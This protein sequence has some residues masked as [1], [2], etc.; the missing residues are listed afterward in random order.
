MSDWMRHD[1][2]STQAME[3]RERQARERQQRDQALLADSIYGR[4][5][6]YTP[7]STQPYDWSSGSSKPSSGGGTDWSGIFGSPSTTSSPTTTSY[8][9]STSYSDPV[10][11][12]I[13]VREYTPE[14]LEE[15]RIRREE[16]RIRRE[17]LAEKARQEAAELR[18]K[19]I[20]LLTAPHRA[21]RSVFKAS[22]RNDTTASA[23][24]YGVYAIGIGAVIANGIHQDN[25]RQEY[26]AISVYADNNGKIYAAKNPGAETANLEASRLCANGRGWFGSC[27]PI[28]NVAAGEPACISTAPDARGGVHYDVIKQGETDNL[29]L[30]KTLISTIGSISYI[31]NSAEMTLGGTIPASAAAPIQPPPTA[32]RVGSANSG[33]L[34]APAAP[35]K[36]A[37]QKRII[38]AAA[39]VTAPAV[40]QALS[41]DR[42]L[43]ARAHDALS[44]VY[45]TV[46]AEAL[47][48]RATPDT[49]RAPLMQISEGSCLLGRRVGREHD[50]FV[51][52]IVFNAA[53]KGYKTGYVSENH[54]ERTTAPGADQCTARLEP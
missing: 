52:V 12:S 45:Y 31:C 47:N 25:L 10:A 7:P 28:A 8:Y 39:A 30:K 19:L 27:E 15:I 6:F 54:V 38:P 13:P 32:Q 11:P 20:E 34:G 53:G 14:E 18:K 24:T 44:G 17:A 36:A 46:T 4:N 29:A 35:Q 5:T 21:L 43:T 26:P 23:L 42:V 50:G 51:P 1:I 33:S 9:P 16:D 41:D 2:T 48:L 40:S 3:M 22:F 49:S 37:E